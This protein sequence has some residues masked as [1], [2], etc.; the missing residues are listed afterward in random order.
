MRK[1]KML[2]A[3]RAFYLDRFF[4]R[5]ERTFRTNL[6]FTRLVSSNCACAGVPTV[7]LE[8]NGGVFEWRNPLK[9]SQYACTIMDWI[10]GHNAERE[11]IAL[12]TTSLWS[13]ASFLPD[14]YNY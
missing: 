1:Q 10:L 9:S 11:G 12:F 6:Q 5:I 13:I 4:D 2:D 8:T 7:G 3:M 14:C